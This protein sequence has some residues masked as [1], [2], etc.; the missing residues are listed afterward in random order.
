MQPPTS[1][2]V[3]P[4]PS[5]PSTLNPKPTFASVPARDQPLGFAIDDLPLPSLNDGMVTV[6]ISENSF[7]RGLDKCK[8]ILVGKLLSPPNGIMPRAHELAQRLKLFWNSVSNW[9]VAPMGKGFFMLQFQSIDD[10]QRI[11]SLG[12]ISLNPGI[13]RLIK[14]TPDFSPSSYKNTFVQIWVRFWDLGFAYW[15][16]QTLFEI[17]RGIGTPIKLDP[18]TANRSIGLYA[19]VLVDVD[20]SMP[21]RDKIKV[22][23]AQ[24]LST[25]ASVE[26]ESAR[27]V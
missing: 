23:R 20:L 24:G 12:S 6:Q 16:Q 26:Y 19:R 7:L 13:M 8:T 15:D 2:S 21:L 11:C 5:Q 4:D 17:A 18:R 14:W 10:M 3:G 27:S 9:S 1:T 25:V 22:A